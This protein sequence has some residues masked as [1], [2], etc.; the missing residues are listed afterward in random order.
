MDCQVDLT[1]QVGVPAELLLDN[2]SNFISM[3][4]WQFCETVGIR[5]IRTSPYHPQ[6][7][8]MVEQFNSTFKHLLRKHT[9]QPGI[10]WD[11]CLP[12]VLWAYWGTS[13]ETTGFSPY[14]IMH[15]REMNIP[16]DELACFWGG[17]EGEKK[18]VDTVEYIQVVK[19]N[20][21]L[22]QEMT[23]EK[24][25]ENQKF[26]YDRKTIERKFIVGD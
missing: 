20:M 10:E 2:V 11:K 17:G 4:V 16:M 22:V 15:G 24:E 12:F 5:R 14:Q 3:T 23:R 21:G 26:Y 18:E 7:D 25:K 13:P 6:T 19:A 1:A 8:G 9:Q